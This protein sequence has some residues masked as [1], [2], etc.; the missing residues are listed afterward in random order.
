MR[1]VMSL[2]ER[3]QRVVV[4]TGICVMVLFTLSFAGDLTPLTPGNVEPVVDKPGKADAMPLVHLSALTIDPANVEESLDRIRAS[5]LLEVT[6]KAFGDDQYVLL[7]VKADAQSG[8][9]KALKA[10]DVTL[11]DYIPEQTYLARVPAGKKANLKSTHECITWVGEFRPYYKLSR[12]VLDDYQK[13]QPSMIPATIES[14]GM[15]IRPAETREE[16]KEYILVCFPAIDTKALSETLEGLGAEV[17]SESSTDFKVKL[18]VK[19]E[20]ATLGDISRIPQVKWVEPKPEWKLCNDKARAITDVPA[21]WAWHDLPEGLH[22]ANQVVAVTDTGIDRGTYDPDYMHSDFL[23][24]EGNLRIVEYGIQDLVDDGAQDDHG[25]GTHVA[26]SILGNGFASG[27]DPLNHDYPSFCYAGMAP[28][29]WLLFQALSLDE[30]GFLLGIPTDLNNLFIKSYRCDARLHN[31]SWSHVPFYPP[32]YYDSQAQDVDEFSWTHPDYTI[33]YSAGNEGLDRDQDGVIDRYSLTSPGTAKNNV[34]VGASENDRPT[35]SLTWGAWWALG[36]PVAPIAPDRVANNPDGMAAFSSRGPT[37]DGRYKPD[38]VAPGT[39]ITSTKAFPSQEFV[40]ESGYDFC[41][42]TITIEDLMYGPSRIEV[43]IFGN[44]GNTCT[45]FNFNLQFN[46]AIMD[47]ISL[48]KGTE[49]S[50]W[51]VTPVLNGSKVE[52]SGMGGPSI[53]GEVWLCTLTFEI[54][55]GTTDYYTQMSGT[56]MSSPIACGIGTLLREFLNINGV[57]SPSSSLIKAMMVSGCEDMYP[58]QYGTGDAQEIPVPAPNDVEG[59]GRVNAEKSLP[60]TDRTLLFDDRSVALETGQKVDYTFTVVDDTQPLHAR[61]AWVD[62]PGST[63]A[64]FHLVNDLDLTLTLP[65]SSVKTAMNPRQKSAYFRFYN[66]A[67]NDT[68]VQPAEFGVGYAAQ[69]HPPA[70]P[71]EPS[72]IIFLITADSEEFEEY[73]FDVYLYNEGPDGKPG[74]VLKVY[75]DVVAPAAK[76]WMTRI[77]LPL[78]NISVPSGSVFVEVRWGEC[79]C[80]SQEFD[81]LSSSVDTVS[82]NDWMR[83]T[84]GRW[85][86]MPNDSILDLGITLVGEKPLP[87]GSRDSINNVEGIDITVPQPGTYTLTVSA[88]DVNYGPQDFSVVISGNVTP[89]EAAWSFDTDPEGWQ[90][91]GGVCK[92]GKVLDYSSGDGHL[93]LTAGGDVNVFGYWYSPM[94]TIDTHKEYRARFL[95]STDQQDTDQVPEFR[96]RINQGTR[97]AVWTMGVNSFEGVSPFKGHPKSYD[98]FFKPRGTAIDTD[99][100]L[101]LDLLSFNYEDDATSWLYLEEAS[102]DILK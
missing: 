58:G 48:E 100:S 77:M 11:Y 39:F 38:L 101:S 12:A 34:S 55:S 17:L 85:F 40:I 31:N 24:G 20:T 51:T 10:D 22:G 36:F 32:A 83:S 82:G 28:E 80:V 30:S 52:V 88:P 6:E 84:T 92:N 98:V 23:D 49:L 19:T 9:K 63:L 46:S 1:N 70:Y 27:G 60:D 87:E 61:L 74:N 43:E 95:V 102:I 50:D 35:I 89:H 47:F 26:G 14:E 68:V 93:G 96:L 64:D 72:L 42:G 97:N 76:D 86:P 21:A 53:S 57:P 71:F 78:K 18:L 69:F 13:S 2:S 5:G 37:W 59:W 66:A 62:Y 94:I 29:A 54:I 3:T 41:G 65:D 4:I 79:C 7:Q 8:W 33:F 91:G 56:S 90:F 25:H 75:K 99:I 16:I 81:L 15:I 73:C 67:S 44:T 45:S